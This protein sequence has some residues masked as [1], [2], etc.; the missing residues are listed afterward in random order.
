MV[1]NYI[2][3]IRK[4]PDS[5]YGVD[6][7]D[8]LG[9][10]SAG[11]TLQEALINAAEALSFHIEGMEE[12]G[13]AIPAPSTLD[14]IFEDPDNCGS[15]VKLAVQVTPDL[16]TKAV[17]VNITVNETVLRDIDRHAR[18]RG[19]NRSAFLSLAAQEEIRRGAEKE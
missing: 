8:F 4:D 7:P 12:D 10:I 15:D 2:A 6:F 3:L 13:L 11:D 16:H 9:C 19:M 1:A 5:C 14:E 18:R 17:R